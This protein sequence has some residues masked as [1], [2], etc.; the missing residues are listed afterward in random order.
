MQVISGHDKGKVGKITKVNTKTGTVTVEGVNIKTK[1][2]K[3]T[4]QV[5]VTPAGQRASSAAIKT[6][7]HSFVLGIRRCGGWSMTKQC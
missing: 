1:H 2:V 5:R 6:R 3:P 4:A 7:G